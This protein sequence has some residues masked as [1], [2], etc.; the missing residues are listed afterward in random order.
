VPVLGVVE[1]MSMHICSNCGHAEAIF[2][3]GGGKRM[4]EQYGVAWLGGLPL[5]IGIRE[6]TDAGNPTVIADPAS[7][8]A[9]LY[10][11]IARRVAVAVAGLP[12]DMA[13]KFPNVVVQST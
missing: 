4:A 11:D 1:N 10:R 9:G 7:E 12:K 8:A 5:T 3:Q 6:Q 2:G 13:G